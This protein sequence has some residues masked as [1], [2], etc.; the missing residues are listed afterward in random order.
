MKNNLLKYYLV[1]FCLCSNFA[2]FAQQPGGTNDT[3]DMEGT[4]AAAAPIDDFI[5]VLAL[6]ALVYVF[7]KLRANQNNKIQG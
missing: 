6:M 7:L 3:S 2:L 4:D 5:W 1:F